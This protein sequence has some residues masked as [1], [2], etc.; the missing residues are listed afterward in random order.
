MLHTYQV[1]RIYVSGCQLVFVFI[2]CLLVYLSA[3]V[4]ENWQGVRLTGFFHFIC[5]LA[6]FVLRVTIFMLARRQ[7]EPSDPH[8]IDGPNKGRGVFADEKRER[9][10]KKR[11]QIDVIIVEHTHSCTLTRTHTH[12]QTPIHAPPK[13]TRIIYSS[14]A[15]SSKKLSIYQHK[16]SVQVA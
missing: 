16:C 13:H 4:H 15:Q 5:S 2:P 7:N 11:I 6:I 1:V 10:Q 9:S 12:T 3:C 8:Q 14:S